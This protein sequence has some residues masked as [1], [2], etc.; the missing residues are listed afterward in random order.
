MLSISASG[1]R[2]MNFISYSVVY[3]EEKA[4]VSGLLVG[5]SYDPT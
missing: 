3:T 4:R 5:S 1:K 2:V